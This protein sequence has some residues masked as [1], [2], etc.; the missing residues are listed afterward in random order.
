MSIFYIVPKRLAKQYLMLLMKIFWDDIFSHTRVI[1]SY[2]IRLDIRELEAIVCSHW[3]PWIDG[4]VF[5]WF[6]WNKKELQF[7]TILSSLLQL[8]WLTLPA[9]AFSVCHHN[10]LRPTNSFFKLN[11]IEKLW[12]YVDALLVKITS[13]CLVIWT[14]MFSCTSLF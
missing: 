6:I 1:M 12:S 2:F 5:T 7:V 9:I 13:S 10:L 3:C 11:R 4:S 14:M 8:R